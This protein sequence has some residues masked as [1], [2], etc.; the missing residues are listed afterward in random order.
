MKLPNALESDSLNAQIVSQ[1]A[2]FISVYIFMVHMR[3]GLS[4][5]VIHSACVEGI[6]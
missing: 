1:V 5:A 6:M 3:C 4:V 2:I